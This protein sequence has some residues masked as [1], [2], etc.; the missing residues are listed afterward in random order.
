MTCVRFPI[1]RQGQ[2]HGKSLISAW[3]F[4]ERGDALLI[5]QVCIAC[6]LRVPMVCT[7]RRSIDSASEELKS[8]ERRLWKG[9]P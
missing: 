5:L 9:A 8:T 6:R 3:W 7:W 2:T 4:S 1:G